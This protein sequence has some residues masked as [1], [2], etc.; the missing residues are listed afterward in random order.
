MSAMWK[1]IEGYPKYEVS[2][3]GEVR[4]AETHRV[5]KSFDNKRGY[6]KV[7]LV[8]DDGK[9]RNV[10][11][12]RLVAAAYVNNLDPETRTQVNHI[13]EVKTDNRAENLEWVTPSQN[14]RHGSGLRRRAASQELPVVMV[15]DGLSV[16]F[17]SAMDAER[18]TGIPAKNIQKCCTGRMKSTRGAAFAYLGAKVVAE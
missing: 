5:L 12:H 10:S 18:R 14:I 4:N 3:S 2:N 17:D 15:Y 11:V 7:S 1:K 16:V 13:N 9:Q 8:G 6:L